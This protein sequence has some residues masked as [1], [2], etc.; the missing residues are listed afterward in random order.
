VYTS[1]VAKVEEEI[2]LSATRPGEG[3]NIQMDIK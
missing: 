2:S 3:D 1:L